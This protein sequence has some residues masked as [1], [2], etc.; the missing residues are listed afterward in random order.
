M[1]SGIWNRQEYAKKPPVLEHLP[2]TWYQ[3]LSAHGNPAV[4]AR[5]SNIKTVRDR[6]PLPNITDQ[7]GGAKIFTKI[8]LLKGYFQVAV[9]KEDIEKTAIITCFSTYTFIY[10]CFGLQNSV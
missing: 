1:L 4:T 7:M 3:S 6:Y 9:A 5:D 10:S 2:Y 8:D